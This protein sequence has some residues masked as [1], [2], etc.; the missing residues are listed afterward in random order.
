[1]ENAAVLTLEFKVSQQQDGNH[2]NAT[3]LH[4]KGNRNNALNYNPNSLTSICGKIMQH[5]LHNQIMKHL[6]IHWILTDQQNGLK[7]KRSCES[8]LILTGQDLAAGLRDG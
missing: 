8:Q 4:I 6:A 5:I 7:K 3:P 1:M 2:A